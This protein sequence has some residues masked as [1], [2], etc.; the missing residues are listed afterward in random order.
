MKM[1]LLKSVNPSNP[2]GDT[3]ICID[4]N[5][6]KLIMEASALDRRQRPELQS[7]IFTP[8]G[9]FG[10]RENHEKIRQMKEEASIL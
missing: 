7:L 4:P 9:Q 1:I 2:E 6:I 3:V 5:E 8:F 10:V